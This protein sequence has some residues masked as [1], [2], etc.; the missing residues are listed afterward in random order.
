TI[1]GILAQRLVRRLCGECRQSY[2]P[3]PGY[4]RQIGLSEDRVR[5]AQLW[6]ARGCPACRGTGYFGRISI[7]E[8]MPMSAEIRR[9]I[10]AHA[11]T[12]EIER[13]AID[14]GMGTMFASGMALALAGTTTVEEVLRA[15]RA[16]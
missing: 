3:L 12:Q 14:A 4:F 13:S 16:V 11:E 8:L 6:R 2:D 5:R 10:L 15:T 1:N 7:L 9:L